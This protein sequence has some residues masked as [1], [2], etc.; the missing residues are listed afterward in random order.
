[1]LLRIKMLGSALSQLL[2]ILTAGDLTK[3]GPNESVSARAYRQNLPRERWINAIF[4][5]QGNHCKSAYMSDVYDAEELLK[6]HK[7]IE[8]E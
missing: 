7:R 3:T 1:M 2:N 5:L 8:S 6:E 4:F